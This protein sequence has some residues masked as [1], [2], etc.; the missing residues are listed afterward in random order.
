MLKLEV[1][2]TLKNRDQIEAVSRMQNYIKEHLHEIITLRNLS[3][4]AGYSPWHCARIFKEHTGKLLLN[5]FGLL[6][7]QSRAHFKR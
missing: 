6:G 1:R 4:I 3:E 5:I 7:C 2:I